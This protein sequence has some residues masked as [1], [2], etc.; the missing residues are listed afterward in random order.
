MESRSIK[1]EFGYHFGLSRSHAVLL[2]YKYDEPFVGPDASIF[3]MKS[4]CAS[5]AVSTPVIQINIPNYHIP[6]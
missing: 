5:D 3:L 1:R 6:S 4:P 2:L